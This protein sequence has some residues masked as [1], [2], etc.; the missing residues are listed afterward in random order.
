MYDKR[1]KQLWSQFQN[2][3][4]PPIYNPEQAANSNSRRNSFMLSI[5]IEQPEI[6]KRIQSITDRIRQIPGVYVMPTEYYH[7]TVKWLGFL[8]FQKQHDYDI[9]PQMFDQI[10]ELADGI[11]SRVPAFPIRLGC[12][13]ALESFIVI[14]VEDNGT[15]AQIQGRFHEKATLVPNYSIEGEQWLPHLS[16]AGLKSHEGLSELQATMDEL[17]HIEIGEIQ[18][19]HIDLSQAILQKPCP[20]CRI[21]RLF[22]LA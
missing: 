21:L 7:I 4:N 11:V 10:L 13:N 8:T 16:I 18:V 15:I 12:V 3:F 22:P 6:L 14:E 1:F 20:E 2:G 9:E 17:R 19:T 5:P